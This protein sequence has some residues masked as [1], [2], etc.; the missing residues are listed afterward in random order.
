MNRWGKVALAFVAWLGIASVAAA[1]GI[2]TG[3]IQGTVVDSSASVLP[4][5]TVTVSSPA[6]QGT[7]D[8]VTDANG[9]YVLRGLPPGSYRVAVT[10]SGFGSVERTTTVELGRPSQVDVAL[11]VA[12]VQE[13]V[14][15]RG[16]TPSALTTTTGG[17]NYTYEEINRLPTPRTLAGIAA[18]A[19]GL[20]ENTPNAGQVTISGGF[21]Y[22]NVFLIDGVDVNDNLFGTANNL[23]IEDAIE[24]TQVLT[25]GISAEYGRFSGGVVN[26]ISKSGGNTFA[27][28]FRTNL[29]NVSWRDENPIEKRNG[30]TRAD[31]LSETY[32][33]TFGGPILR[34]RLWFFGAGRWANTATSTPLPETNLQFEGSSEN[35]R[36]EGKGTA[37]VAR[38]HTFTGSYLRNSTE[39]VRVA[40]PFTIDPRAAE[41]PSFP[42]DR[43]VGSWRG[44][45]NPRTFAEVQV[46]RKTFGFRNT[47]GTGSDLALNS[48]II[49]AFT[50]PLSAYNA[51]YFD[52]TDPEDRNNYQIAGNLSYFLTTPNMGSHD[53]KGGVEWFNSTNTG[54]NSQ[55]PTGFVWIA[56][57]KVD[58][59][60]DPVYDAQGRLI[61]TFVTGRNEYENWLPERGAQIDIRTVSVFFQDRWKAGRHWA[62][63]LGTR[64]ER[65]RSEATGG[66]V[67][68]DTDTIVPRL[69]ATYDVNGDG[70]YILQSTYG[71]YAG[72]YSEAQFSS[73]TTVGN[74]SALY[75]FYTGPSGEGLNFAPGFD[76]RNYEIYNAEFPTANV[77]FTDGLS[78]PLTKEFTASFGT[79]LGR[80]YAKATFQE[81]RM[82][83]FVE[84]FITLDGGATDIVYQGVE[85]GTFPNVVYQNSD[86][87]KREYRALIFEGRYPFFGSKLQVNGHW[88]VQLRNHGN[89]EGEGQNT[90][91]ISS[92]LG[93]YPEIFSE[94][95]YYP[96]GRLND[97]QRHKTRLWGIYT[98]GLG[99]IGT[100]DASAIYRYDS[101]TS[102][103]LFHNNAPLSATQQSLG[104]AYA[105]LPV[106]KS[107]FFGERG[108]GTFEDSHLVDVALNYNIPVFRSLRPWVKFEARNVLNND[109]LIA[110]NT[111]VT[112]DPNSAR[113]AFGLPTGYRE[114]GTFGTGTAAGHYPIPREFF[115][116]LGLRF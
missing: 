86:D 57:Y 37:T 111:T 112:G 99:R 101:A 83:N 11:A 87:P 90:P 27:G 51:P 56:D 98:L 32:E 96:L 28:T 36:I 1:Q 20:T 40:F 66:I 12:G 14:T 63:D 107:L 62:F 45:L 47:G 31:N 52:A 74:P 29:T 46:S 106:S 103:S 10:L 69:A 35:R 67:G 5:A 93:D 68:V 65:V 114:G 2:Q 3:I 104:A 42:N 82:S 38:N 102:F 9:V 113:D 49:G 55:S 34:D 84:D 64:Y 73:N 95:R 13:A 75:A 6:L 18:L 80:G 61:P 21:A 54:G 71:H 43:F 108:S 25:S 7:R 22:D 53:F 100:L 92:T 89:F 78:S 26:A 116:S 39:S 94:A 76:P 17:A 88:T 24:Q 50:V 23:F 70:R 109:K 30:T 58:A 79:Q 15:V 72:K 115:V 85:Y 33:G 91:G 97:Y 19:P 16:E 48:P 110:W 77:F 81:R 41:E 4:G 8:T 59:A 60:G 44:V 105:S